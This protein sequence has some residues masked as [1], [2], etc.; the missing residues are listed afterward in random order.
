MSQMVAPTL[1]TVLCIEWGRPGWFVMG[2]LIVLA[3]LLM[4]PAA[5]WALRTR[6]RYGVVTHTG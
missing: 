4:V 6:E 5:D 1:V 3:G 2:A